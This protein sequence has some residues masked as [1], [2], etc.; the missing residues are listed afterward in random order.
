MRI[1]SQDGRVD[2]PYEKIGLSAGFDDGKEIIAYP[3]ERTSLDDGFWSLARY[4]SA[5]KVKKAME[6]LRQSYHGNIRPY[7][8]A[9]I[10]RAKINESSEELE[11]LLDEV[12]K[13]QKYFQFPQDNDLEV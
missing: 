13:S 12:A 9:F 1:L 4:S 11:K 3:I 10:L 7:M 6:M 2:L 5:D 8:D